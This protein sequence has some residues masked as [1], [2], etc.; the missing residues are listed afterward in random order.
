MKEKMFLLRLLMVLALFTLSRAPAAAGEPVEFADVENHWAAE[1]IT[2]CRTYQFMYGY[3]GN[4]FMPD[5]NLTRAEA[6]V[7]IGRSL[8]WDKQVD[9]VPTAGI[10]FP[11]DLLVSFRGYVALAA[12][13]QLIGREAIPGL[14]FN[15][16]VSRMEIAQWL[17]RALNLTG[18]APG[19]NFSDLYLIPGS[20]R[21]MLAGVV[22][23]GIIKGL[24]GNLFAPSKPLTRAE[25]ATILVRMIDGGKISPL[26]GR[27]VT[28][29]IK[30]VEWVQQKINVELPY[31]INTYEL[32]STYI[33]FRQ[34]RKSN[35]YDIVAG[36]S[37][38][39]SINQSGR[40][41]IIAYPDLPD[42]IERDT[43]G[44]SGGNTYSGGRRGYV[45]N[46]YWDYFTV[47]YDHGTVEQIR[48]A[49][50]SF[51]KS[52]FS[53]S[54]GSLRRGDYVD[55][56]KSGSAVR[57][58]RILDG[59]RKVFGEVGQ[60]TGSFITVEDDDS[61]LIDFNL[62]RSVRVL[63]SEGDRADMY[64]IEVGDDVELTLDDN[65]YVKEI[66]ISRDSGDD[67]EGR[68]EDIRTS[69]TKKIII[70]DVD[71]D[72]HTYYLAN[73]FTVREDGFSRD[74]G[75]VEEG[76][77]VRLTL[78]DDRRVT[79][80]DITEDE[81]TVEGEVDYLTT[82]GT[83]RIR[84]EK[85]NGD[86]KT[87]DLD[88]DVTVREYGS[89]RNL[90]DVRE[91]MEVRL[92]LNGSGYVTRIDILDESDTSSDAEG[93]V[94][95]LQ[96]TGS[97]R[98]IEI[99]ESDGDERAYDLADGVTV[100]DNGEV[101]S[102]YYIVSGMGVKLTLNSRGDVTRID[103]GEISHTYYAEGEVTDIRRTGT[104]KIEIREKDGDEKTYYLDDY[105]TVRED[106]SW[107]DLDDVEVGMDVKL[108]LDDGEVTRIDIYGTSTA[109]GEVTYIRTTGTKKI[110]IR[111]SDGDEETYYLDHDVEV[112]ENGHSRD[113]DDIEDGMDVELTLDDDEKVTS[114]DI[115]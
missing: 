31:G 82:S 55:L 27:Q 41:V 71:G 25:M 24:P 90:D 80:I 77:R 46:K 49:G 44:Q 57:A 59:A 3:P 10:R 47:R 16:P 37:V 9:G 96:A 87:Y 78:D 89:R 93:E 38:K 73:S 11:A 109:R 113:L 42:S 18:S 53:S 75:D 67:T 70:K 100:H 94:T 22:E 76:M 33:V 26:Y 52:G 101:R 65:D 48:T 95:H 45:A 74:L 13:K 107:R 20:S 106:G 35:L 40:C 61:R 88:D 110:K 91:G 112:R 99:K 63:D 69:G 66:R 29:K 58:V 14:K 5:R 104:K 8:G 17:A 83:D 105:V 2:Q 6:L 1:T 79:R 21:G 19:L 111:E 60:F 85:R 43:G 56:E 84:I 86:L 39:L 23:A 68:V 28:G 92:T 98:Y 64:D 50:V 12:N 102:L 97:N 30:S 114:I 4:L 103:I 72:T 62:S 15:E 36:E 115:L 34:G 81:S 54:Y 51:F 32:D 108:T 7:V